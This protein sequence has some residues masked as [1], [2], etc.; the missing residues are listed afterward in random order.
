MATEFDADVIVVGSGAVGSNMANELAKHGKSVIMLEAGRKVP[1][2]KLVENFRNSPRKYDFNEPFP[3]SPWAHTSYAEGYIEN[4]GSF[5]M[6]P[7]MLKLVGGTTWHW[8]GATWRYLPNDM[9]LKTL[10]GVG[11][12]WPIEYSD[13][14]P[15]YHRAEVEL[16]VSGS[17]TDDQS[18]QGGTAFPPRSA[19][20]PV[21]PEPELYLYSHFRKKL[22]PHGYRFA[23]EP[24]VRTHVPYDERPACQGNNNCAPVCPIGALYNGSIHAERAERRG[25]KLITDA[26]AY[27]I[28]KGEK[29]R[30][31]AVHYR[32]S[33]G[34]D[35]RLTARYFVIAAHSFETSKLLLLSDVANSSDQVGR[36]LMDHIG[37][38]MH[39][40]AEEPLWMGR[41]PVQ[42]GGIFNWR[43]GDFRKQHSALKHTITNLNPQLSLT[44]RFLGEGMMGKQLDENIMNYSARWL[45]ISTFFESLPSPTN[46]VQPSRTRKDAL[47]I[48]MIDVHF[49]V[50]DYVKAGYRAA[51]D[52]YKDIVAKMNGTYIETTGFQNHDHLMGTMIMGKDPKDSVVDGD[53]RTHDHENLFIASVGVIPAAGVVNPTLTAI[54]LSIRSADIIAHEV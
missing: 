7:G 48:P 24:N 30:I 26:T 25:V 36:N 52:H 29:N 27:K 53:C 51:Q 31:V 32:S 23:H 4:T 46:R 54:A 15:Y 37:V 44:Q 13:L 19:P 18:G 38:N 28:E 39:F 12:D 41:G 14:E 34:E 33:T 42:Q 45:E 11:R 49:D 17:D 35:V 20:Y 16:G 21:T 8:G 3:N 1:R 43:D 47:G 9:K 40:L 10:Y 22:E 50:D 5:R 6:L 2:W